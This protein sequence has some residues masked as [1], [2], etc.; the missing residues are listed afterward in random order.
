M[1]VHWDNS[2]VALTGVVWSPMHPGFGS[3]IHFNGVL[4]RLMP[5]MHLES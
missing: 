3:L 4:L 2:I 5:E 1:L